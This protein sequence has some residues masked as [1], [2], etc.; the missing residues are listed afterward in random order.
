MKIN[1][2]KIQNFEGVSLIDLTLSKPVTMFV[3]GNGQGKSGIAEAVKLALT[4]E[5]GRDVEKKADYKHLI[6]EGTKK[7]MI[8]V[9]LDTGDSCGIDILK[10]KSM[11]SH[12]TG[13]P[14]LPYVLEASRFA[15]SD[16]K[17][18]RTVLMKATGANVS[19]EKVKEML[20]ARGC[21]MVK[22]EQALP[23]LRSG[24]PAAESQCRDQAREAKADWKAVT[25]ETWGSD[26]GEVWEPERVEFDAGAME[27][28]KQQHLTAS[29]RFGKLNKEL[30]ELQGRQQQQA[31][32]KERT[33][34]LEENAAL[35]DRRQKALEAAQQQLERE[36]DTCKALA[37]QAGEKPAETLACP[38]CGSALVLQNGKLVEYVAPK[39]DPA[40][41]E[42]LKEHSAALVTLRNTVANREKDLAA[43]VQAVEALNNQELVDFDPKELAAKEQE[44]AKAREMMNELAVELEELRELQHKAESADKKATQAT[45]HHQSVLA[46]LDLA[47]A[48]SPEGIPGEIVA[49]A[50]SPINNRLAQSAADTGWMT[51]RINAEMEITADGRRYSSLSE[52]EKWR[53]NAMFAEA[54][55]YVSGTK[56]LVLDGFD[57]IEVESRGSLMSW[58]TT[59]GEYGDVDTL[60]CCGT[61]KKRPAGNEWVETHW[62]EAGE[63]VGQQ[64]AEAA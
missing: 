13:N 57:V 44:I 5:T 2:L 18:R 53:C 63:I 51:P 45:A 60:I 43:S 34:Q 29:E 31:N 58:L 3:G 20:K 36:E 62:I 61:L 41:A 19:T 4:G 35:L 8:N 9:Q 22:A 23:L 64:K 17:E 21:D 28:L 30:G 10:S 15:G 47:E 24:F 25:G 37:E 46:W 32:I 6:K 14:I 1:T 26:K 12:M 49:T 48:F 42:R 56:L 50:L 55:S 59:L 39:F 40:A 33:K 7:S 52:S 27:T 16:S 11:G 54:I 38:G